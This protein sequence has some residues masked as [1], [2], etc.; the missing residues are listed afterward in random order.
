MEL[1]IG[2]DLSFD[3][4]Y[5]CK[6]M[7]EKAREANSTEAHTTNDE[8]PLNSQREFSLAVLM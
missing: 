7:R 2:L 1:K 8:T 5:D 4:I 3:N 6:G